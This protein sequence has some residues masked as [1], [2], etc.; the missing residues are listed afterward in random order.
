MFGMVGSSLSVLVSKHCG[1]VN[2][3]L[4]E[5]SDV[6][7]LGSGGTLDIPLRFTKLCEMV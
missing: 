6:L 1:R 5:L 4:R 7:P 3:S 2:F